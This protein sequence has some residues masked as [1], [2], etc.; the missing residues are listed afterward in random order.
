MVCLGNICRS[1]L[2][3]G[4]LRDK[5]LQ[6]KLAVNVDSA[7]TANYHIGGAPD[8]RMTQTA[9]NNGIDISGLR[10]RQFEVSDFDKFDWIYVM[11]QSNFTNVTRM[12]RHEMDAK[13]VKL[14]LSELEGSNDR[15]V[16]DPYYG[17]QDGFDRVY[18]MLDQATEQILIKLLN[19]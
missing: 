10:A 19:D 1:P 2:A 6:K 8:L 9:Q 12:A 7:G 14:I 15:E 5:V 16:P 17:E 18:E 4:L 11:D 13:K 3:D